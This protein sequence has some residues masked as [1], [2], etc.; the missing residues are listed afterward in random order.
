VRSIIAYGLAEP[1]N[2]RRPRG[3]MPPIDGMT[4][5]E[6]ASPR[7]ECRLVRQG[8]ALQGPV[9]GNEVRASCPP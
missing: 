8:I 1:L 7:E 4:F 5:F 9:D 2:L 3:V 6:E